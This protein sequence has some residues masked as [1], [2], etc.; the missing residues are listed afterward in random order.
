VCDHF[1]RLHVCK[2]IV[3]SMPRISK[4]ISPCD[5]IEIIPFLVDKQRSVFSLLFHIRM[6]RGIFTP[7]KVFFLTSKSLARRIH[8]R[9]NDH[10]TTEKITLFFFKHKGSN[11]HLYTDMPYFSHDPRSTCH[12]STTMVRGTLIFPK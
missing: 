6:Y 3:V 12:I 2:L 5:F 7:T 10:T 1:R 8:F 4:Y 11:L 9:P